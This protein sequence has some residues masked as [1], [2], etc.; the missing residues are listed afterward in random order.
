MCARSGGVIT[1]LMA[2]I[3]RVHHFCCP[4]PGCRRDLQHGS[5]STCHSLTLVRQ[6]PLHY[7]RCLC[8]WHCCWELV[9]YTCTLQFGLWLT[10]ILGTL[11]TQ[12]ICAYASTT[13]YARVPVSCDGRNID[14]ARSLLV[15]PIWYLC[16]MYMT[17]HYSPTLAIHCSPHLLAIASQ[18]VRFKNAS[19]RI[20]PHVNS[21]VSVLHIDRVGN[22]SARSTPCGMT[23][24]SPLRMWIPLSVS[25]FT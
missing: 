3:P 2:P 15:T 13:T 6:I 9:M 17:L 5:I 16:A 10:R 11:Y 19:T 7:C 14:R 4:R 24:I 12:Y 25:Q 21:E 22:R 8:F 23:R 1:I 18:Y 20:Q